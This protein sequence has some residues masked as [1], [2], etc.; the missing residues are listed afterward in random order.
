MIRFCATPHAAG[1]PAVVAVD[2]WDEMPAVTLT[3]STATRWSFMP[4]ADDYH[5]VEVIVL[6]HRS[7]EA[8][9]RFVHWHM[10]A[11]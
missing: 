11:V 2:T 6:L 7:C 9:A 4:P 5:V 1:E 8:V 3:V 10:V